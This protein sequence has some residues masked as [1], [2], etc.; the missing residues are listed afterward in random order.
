[1]ITNLKSE[2]ALQEVWRQDRQ[3]FLIVEEKRVDEA[4]ELLGGAEPVLVREIGSR[5]AYLFE[6]TTQQEE[7]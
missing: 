2:E 1:M 7:R 5:T 4:R 3:A 6:N